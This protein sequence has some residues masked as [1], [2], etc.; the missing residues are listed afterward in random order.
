M[1][2]S[3]NVSPGI[4]I[5]C[6]ED[7]CVAYHPLRNETHMLGLLAGDLL[8]QLQATG[9]LDVQSMLVTDTESDAASGELSSLLHQLMDA[10]LIEQSRK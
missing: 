2:I 3:Y 5:R 8:T 6:W 7:G 10:G 1:A 4:S 9:S